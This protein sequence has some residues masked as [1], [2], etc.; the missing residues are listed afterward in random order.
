MSSDHPDIRVRNLGKKYTIGGPL[1]QYLTLRDAMV[2]SVKAPFVRFHRAPPSEEFLSARRKCR[3]M[4]SSAGVVGII[5]WN[6]ADLGK[7]VESFYVNMTTDV[8]DQL[9]VLGMKSILLPERTPNV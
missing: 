2:N 7:E 3:L 5:G 4:W 1:E 9:D 6:G 8:R